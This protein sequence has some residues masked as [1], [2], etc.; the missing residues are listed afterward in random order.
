[1]A[2]ML[3]ICVLINAVWLSDM[4]IK[5]IVITMLVGQLSEYIPIGINTLRMRAAQCGMI[6]EWG[7][8][9]ALR[10]VRTF[11]FDDDN[12]LTPNE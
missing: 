2:L 7:I 5:R 12:G 3:V 4:G 11:R 6:Q 1:M 9:R 10:H 8:A